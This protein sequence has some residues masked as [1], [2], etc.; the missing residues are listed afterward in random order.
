[1]NQHKTD[2]HDQASSQAYWIRNE[3]QSP[4]INHFPCNTSLHSL[5]LKGRKQKPSPGMRTAELKDQKSPAYKLDQT[6][7]DLVPL[8]TQATGPGYFGQVL[9]REQLHIHINTLLHVF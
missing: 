3:G 5:A 6:T 1:M 4:R 8:V 9:S 7:L 2:Y